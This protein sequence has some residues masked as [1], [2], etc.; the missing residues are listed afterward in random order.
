[1]PKIPTIFKPSGVSYN[2]DVI[3]KLNKG[4]IVKMELDN[5]NKYDKN[6]IKILTIDN[7]MCGFV[8]KKYKLDSQEEI[9]LNI[10]IKKKFDKLN[11]KYNLKVNEIY[12]WDGPTGIELIFEKKINSNT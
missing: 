2:Q 10:L 4:D 5:E 9:I 8:P 7:E 3:N 11:K 1:M 12:K 6:A